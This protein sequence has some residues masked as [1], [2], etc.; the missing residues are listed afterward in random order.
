MNAKSITFVLLLTGLGVVALLAAFLGPDARAQDAGPGRFA[1]C[2]VLNDMREAGGLTVDD[3]GVLY[4]TVEDYFRSSCEGLVFET[5]TASALDLLVGTAEP[6]PTPTVRPHYHGV[7]RKH[8]HEAVL[9]E[10]EHVHDEDHS[11]RYVDCDPTDGSTPTPLPTPR[12][13]LAFEDYSLADPV[14]QA[15]P[16]PVNMS[17]LDVEDVGNHDWVMVNEPTVY[18]HLTDM[19]WVRDGVSMGPEFSGLGRLFIMLGSQRRVAASI[20]LQDWFVDGLDSVEA[21][22]ILA[23]GELSRWNGDVALYIVGSPWMV[24]GVEPNGVEAIRLLSLLA[25]IHVERVDDVA[26]LD[27]LDD[28]VSDLDADV[29]AVLGELAVLIDD[30]LFFDIAAMDFLKS[31]D[32]A[33]L[34]ALLSL[35]SLARDHTSEI[36]NI[37]RFRMLRDGIDDSETPVIGALSSEVWRDPSEYED[38]LVP[39]ITSVQERWVDLPLAGAIRVSIVRSD[40]GYDGSMDRLEDVLRSAEAVVGRPFPLAHLSM[41]FTPRMQHGRDYSFDGHQ[42][43]VREVY[44]AETRDDAVGVMS[45]AVA[46]YYWHGNAEWLD[47]GMAE[48]MASVAEREAELRR[49]EE[50]AE[51]RVRN[52]PC[53]YARDIYALENMRVSTWPDCERSLGERLFHDMDIS[54]SDSDFRL[55]LSRL[56]LI[57]SESDARGDMGDVYRAFEFAPVARESVI[58]RWWNRQVN[59]DVGRLDV[60]VSDPALWSLNGLVV[61]AFASFDGIENV[62]F[63]DDGQAPTWLSLVLR[64]RYDYAYRDDSVVL[65][66]VQVYEDGFEYAWDQVELTAPSRTTGW[67]VRHLVGVSPGVRWASGRHWVYLYDR[68][69][70]VAEVSYLVG[71]ESLASSARPDEDERSVR[72]VSVRGYLDRDPAEGHQTEV[73]VVF[74]E[75]VWVSGDIGVSVLG[76]GTL[77][78]RNQTGTHPRID[79]CPTERERAVRKLRFFYWTG[80]PHSKGELPFVAQ[81]DI[82]DRFVL[83]RGA[84]IKDERGGA[85]HYLFGSGEFVRE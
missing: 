31:L 66:V 2:R 27:W 46:G 51:L 10:Y 50:R 1:T 53:G 64:Y 43:S 47:R 4:L 7:C 35:V 33:D 61:D 29:I 71:D 40:Y 59:H 13:E 60:R 21:D 74:S 19:S 72:V 24:D 65:D 30:D 62:E 20:A 84:F 68:G 57:L 73:E 17:L 55:G 22:A 11:V 78:C 83:G 56:H 70:K 36:D 82:I 42:V 15:S 76:K 41:V 69:R 54:M 8:Y 44:D 49:G 80:D 6:E 26:R 5:P 52:V 16:T 63:L 85:V 67:N 18:R 45:A 75:P 38:L 12:A 25:S 32:T 3:H 23:L 48:Y 77:L 81:G 58:P 9:G 14:A 39:S 37:F 34:G 28:G 79:E